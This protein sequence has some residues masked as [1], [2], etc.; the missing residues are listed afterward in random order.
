[1]WWYL[2]PLLVI[3]YLGMVAVSGPLYIRLTQ[4]E[5]RDDY[6]W[7]NE[8]LAAFFWP[9]CL[10]ACLIFCGVRA[11]TVGYARRLRHYYNKTHQVGSKK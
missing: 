7:I 9:V 11:C 5:V 1:M 6:E 4:G 2:T 8:V 3:I 10:P